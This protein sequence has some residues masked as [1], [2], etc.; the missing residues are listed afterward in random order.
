VYN[1][2]QLST[3]DLK[4]RSSEVV[5]DSSVPQAHSAAKKLEKEKG[6]LTL[7]QWAPGSSRPPEVSFSFRK[8]VFYL[9]NHHR[10]EFRT[11]SHTLT[12]RRMHAVMI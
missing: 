2:S 12:T 8:C 10:W 7:R 11:F 1:T 5:R 6:G 4:F 3:G 9:S